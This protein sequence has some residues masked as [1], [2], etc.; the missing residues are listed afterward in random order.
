MQTNFKDWNKKQWN[1]KSGFCILA[2]KSKRKEKYIPTSEGDGD[3][4]G[5][6]PAAACWRRVG[7]A[8]DGLYNLRL[9]RL[10]CLGK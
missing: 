6:L 8:M 9:L 5:K 1:L 2:L 3:D 10:K 4:D 7:E